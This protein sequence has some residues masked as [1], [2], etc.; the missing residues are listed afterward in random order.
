MESAARAH[1]CVRP[2]CPASAASVE[3]I[4]R[5]NERIGKIKER[6]REKKKVEIRARALGT[7]LN[8][9]T[10]APTPAVYAFLSVY[11]TYTVFRARAR[12][13]QLSFFFLLFHIYSDVF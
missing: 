11:N 8:F 9:R 2:L 6:E 1:V 3:H 12:I 7:R 13:G 4:Q 10:A 5:M